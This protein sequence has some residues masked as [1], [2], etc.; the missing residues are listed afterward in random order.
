MYYTTIVHIVSI[1][2]LHILKKDTVTYELIVNISSMK[3]YFAGAI[4]GG[5]EDADLYFKLI[6]HIQNYGEVLTEHVGSSE[7]NG[8]GELTRLDIDIFN[9]DVD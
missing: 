1:I 9:R 2:K 7:L 3:I 4:R 5:R 8:D 6:K